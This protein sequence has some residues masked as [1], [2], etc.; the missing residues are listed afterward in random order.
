MFSWDVLTNKP[1]RYI[2]CNICPTAHAIIHFTYSTLG[3]ERTPLCSWVLF[4]L[5]V[6]L[7][8]T[9]LFCFFYFVFKLF[10]YVANLLGRRECTC[11]FWERWFGFMDPLETSLA[12]VLT[13]GSFCADVKPGRPFTW[14][15]NELPAIVGHFLLAHIQL[16]LSSC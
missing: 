1:Q 16:C 11:T 8:S 5:T 4:A 7:L 9:L 13:E 6:I 2:K 3:S 15:D 10:T 14:V 12:T